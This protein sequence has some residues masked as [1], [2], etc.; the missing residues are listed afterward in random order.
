MNLQDL[1]TR[2]EN[3]SLPL[4]IMFLTQVTRSVG[5]PLFQ[6][7]RGK[8]FL[9]LIPLLHGVALALA[10]I[11]TAGPWRERLL[12]GIIAGLTSIAIYEILKRTSWGREVATYL[13]S[14]GGD[15]KKPNKPDP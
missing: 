7:R 5:R 3:A 10:G 11:G 4:A 9:P 8:D 12:L 15:P 13:E 14:L 2:P 6:S 1:L